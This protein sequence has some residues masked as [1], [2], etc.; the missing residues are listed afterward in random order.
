MSTNRKV[1]RDRLQR[2][3]N[4]L[5]DANNFL[6]EAYGIFSKYGEHYGKYKEYLL[7]IGQTI[8]FAKQNIEKILEHI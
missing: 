4:H 6:G 3:I 5:E 1:L 2:A 8:E 7:A